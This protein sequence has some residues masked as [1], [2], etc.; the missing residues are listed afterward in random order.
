MKN[1]LMGWQP[2]QANGKVAFIIGCIVGLYK[3]VININLPI[4]FGSKLAEGFVMA[5]LCGFGGM[6]GKWV[7]GLIK[8]YVFIPISQHFKIRKKKTK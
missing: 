1:F 2:E 8:L 4:E 7:F 3:Y 6:F 5:S